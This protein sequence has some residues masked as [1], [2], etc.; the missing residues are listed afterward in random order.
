MF[1][2]ATCMANPSIKRQLKA[3]TLHGKCI[4]THTSIRAVCIQIKW[5]VIAIYF[6]C[7]MKWLN[8]QNYI[9]QK[10]MASLCT[11][12]SIS[13]G[14]NNNLI[15]EMSKYRVG[16]FNQQVYVNIDCVL[17]SVSVIVI[18]NVLKCY[19]VV[20]IKKFNSNLRELLRNIFISSILTIIE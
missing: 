13:N 4:A 12:L 5:Y 8:I 2:L 19:T 14:R 1:C 9:V 18:S 10:L 11:H 17:F 20:K 6:I 7:E 3:Y 16:F 15:D